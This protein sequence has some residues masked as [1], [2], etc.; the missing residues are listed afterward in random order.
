MAFKLIWYILYVRNHDKAV[1]GISVPDNPRR[2]STLVLLLHITQTIQPH[3]RWLKG[4][5]SNIFLSQIGYIFYF[6]FVR[7]IT[8]SDTLK[9]FSP[10][11]P[12]HL[13]HRILKITGNVKLYIRLKDILI[14]ENSKQH[15]LHIE[16][17]SAQ[18][19]R[20]P[21]FYDP[22]ISLQLILMLLGNESIQK[23]PFF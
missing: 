4:H 22:L 15:L 12:S 18:L 7:T 16:G 17:E 11:D 6:M 23:C 14:K 10:K 3:H 1:R 13:T 2:F 8:W 20:Y 19:V 5:V 9:L 21:L